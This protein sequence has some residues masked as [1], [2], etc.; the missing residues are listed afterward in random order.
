MSL[1]LAGAVATPLVQAGMNY[2]LGEKFKPQGYDI[3]QLKNTLAPQLQAG[4]FQKFYGQNIM[5][6]SGSYQQGVSNQIGLQNRNN[7]FAQALVNRRSLGQF[8]N[9]AMSA[10]VNEELYRNVDQ[11]TAKTL[12]SMQPQMTQM[13][14]NT[15]QQGVGNV[16]SYLGNIAQAQLTNQDLENAYRQK[17]LSMISPMMNQSFGMFASGMNVPGYA[18]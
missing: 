14:L 4:N 18:A 3:G 13:G 1:A 11:N 7:M 10:K 12:A 16:G 9:P 8:G 15:Y 5:D 2:M 6:P 17:Q